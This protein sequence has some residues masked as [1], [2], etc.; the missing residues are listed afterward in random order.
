M[1]PRSSL[2]SI[3][4][5]RP[6][7]GVYSPVAEA[8]LTHDLGGYGH[9]LFTS[10]N[11]ELGRF[12]TLLEITPMSTE[13]GVRL[14]LR[15][16]NIHDVQKQH[17]DTASEIIERL[18]HLALAIDQ[19]AAYIKYKRMPLDRLGDF[20][21]IYEAERQKI[22]SYTPKKFWEYEHINAFTTWELSFQQL[23][24]GDE[25]WKEGT[26]HFL[27]LSAFFAPTTIT[28][29]L[30]RLYHERCPTDWIRIFIRNGGVQD[31]E[32]SDES[33]TKED[34]QAGNQSSGRGSNDMWD[35]DRFWD[36]IA[37]S[38]ELSLL[39]S[40]SPGTDQE[41]AS[42][43]LHPLIRDWLQLRLKSKKRADYAQEAIL[44]LVCCAAAY[45]NLSTTLGEKTALLT[46]MDG[47]LSNEAE[48]LE[49][50]DWLG[51]QLESCNMAAW[52]AG[53]YSKAGQYRTSEK[54]YRR[55]LE[56]RMSKLGEKHYDT[57]KSMNNLA[58]ALRYLVNFQEAERMHRRALTLRETE[59]GK[60]HPHTL[61]SMSNLAGVL[62][63]LG[64]YE[65]AESMHR[66]SLTLRETLLGKEHPDT[67]ASMNNLALSLSSQ[68]KYEEAER[69]H[70]ETLTLVEKILGNEH[71]D[72]LTNL[73]NLASSLS[74]QKKY[75]EAERIFR[76][77]L[78][79]REMVSGREHPGTLKIM[80]NLAGV[81]CNQEKYEEAKRISRETLKLREIVLGK[82]H[83]DTLVTRENLVYVLR[84]HGKDK[85]AELIAARSM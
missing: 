31:D 42:F 60:E 2:K 18:G 26:A 27:T 55:T 40:I 3:D 37:R 78:I 57:L 12:G 77:T 64:R 17:R 32:E 34:G 61:I 9:V 84:S 63:D 8:L 73:N 66:Q 74:G 35:P 85:E 22:L 11:R 28:E 82:D 68:K 69:I 83:P 30:F 15:G 13:E 50:Q 7:G 81:L 14:L 1:S 36:V 80:H 71:P 23:G 70:R 21:T 38:D 65:E 10:R 76:E 53:F 59:L 52:F 39:Q 58:E 5:S 33:R 62:H 72:T 46:H 49:P 6:V 20:L 67:L 43:S 56:T 45:D 19:A 48:F 51:H 41:G 24:L 75:E 47:S 4:S 25:C 44:V 79:L 16:Y 29:S 54:L